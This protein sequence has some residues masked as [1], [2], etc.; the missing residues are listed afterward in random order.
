M[1]SERDLGICGSI[2]V[3]SVRYWID[4]PL[5]KWHKLSDAEQNG[6]ILKCK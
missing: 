4:K 1:R 6:N 3:H 2:V 5:L